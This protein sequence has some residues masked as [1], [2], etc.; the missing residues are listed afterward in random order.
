MA[1]A[2]D[3]DQATGASKVKY[4]SWPRNTSGGDHAGDEQE[5]LY[6]EGMQMSVVSN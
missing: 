4:S 6:S 3:T 2:G 1:M 5:D